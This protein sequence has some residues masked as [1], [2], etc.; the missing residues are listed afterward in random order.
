MNEFRRLAVCGVVAV[1]TFLAPCPIVAAP[2]VLGTNLIV[3]GD[4]EAGPGS[5]SGAAVASIP[6]WSSSGNFTV[7]QYAAGGG[8]P[9]LTDPGPVSRG[10]NFFAGGTSNP[11]S[12]ASQLIDLSTL[13]NEIDAGQIA[14]QLAGFLGGFSTQ[15][16]NAV[17][18]ASFINGS[19]VQ[20]GS[21]QLGP[22][23][24]ADRASNTG[25]LF[26]DTLGSVPIGTRSVN[27]LLQMT[28]LDG[29]YNDGYADNLSLVLTTPTNVPEPSSF[30]LVCVAA[31]GL[32]LTGKRASK[33]VA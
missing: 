8:F 32:T 11:S 19:N 1:T 31:I 6:N 25:L 3:N 21:A 30:W 15:R 7:V 10:N 33:K 4:A 16:D 17:L 9:T 2:V 12:S 29:S 22:V 5:L 24:T 13:A 28:R 26:R 27:L 23:S 20:L 18:M 14:F